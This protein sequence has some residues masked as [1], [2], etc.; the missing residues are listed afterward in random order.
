MTLSHHTSERIRLA[1]EHVRRVVSDPA[2][3]HQHRDCKQ[4]IKKLIDATELT[5]TSLTELDAHALIR[6]LEKA[7]IEY[8]TQLAA[9]AKLYEQINEFTNR[10]RSELLY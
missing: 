5:S 9:K 1:L 3:S 6:N 10:V 4:C 7:S 8:D 2:T